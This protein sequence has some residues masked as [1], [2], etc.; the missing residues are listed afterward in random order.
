MA[1]QQHTV[2]SCA[3]VVDIEKDVEVGDIVI[4]SDGLWGP[5]VEMQEKAVGSN[6]VKCW[7]VEMNNGRWRSLCHL[8]PLQ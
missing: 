2:D 3:P 4:F 8:T 1:K 7:P 6:W 5:I